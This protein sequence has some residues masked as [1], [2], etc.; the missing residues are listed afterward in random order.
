[1]LQRQ[2]RGIRE[3]VPDHGFVGDEGRQFPVAAEAPVEGGSGEAQ[4]RAPARQR[5]IE[6]MREGEVVD[7]DEQRG[8]DEGDGCSRE[9][10]ASG[11]GGLSDWVRVAGDAGGQHRR[12][13]RF[14]QQTSRSGEQQ[15]FDRVK[16]RRI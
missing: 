12:F 9:G 8:G 7:E 10:E 2:A 13:V 14:P 11:H 16:S 4:R 15:R 5:L 3:K 6:L 1:M